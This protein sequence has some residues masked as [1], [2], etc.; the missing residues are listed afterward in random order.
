MKGSLLLYSAAPRAYT[1]PMATNRTVTV[2]VD[3]HGEVRVELDGEPDP[4]DWVAET[5]SE[6]VP[7]FRDEEY[8]AQQHIRLGS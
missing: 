3:E 6:P 4:K 2:H 8:R 5:P 7:E 1:S